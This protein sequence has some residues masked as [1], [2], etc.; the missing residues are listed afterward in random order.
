MLPPPAATAAFSSA[1]K[2]GVVFRVSRIL[3]PE[4]SI[5]L[6]KRAL[7]ETW[8]HGLEAALELEADLQ[9]E[10]GRTE[11]H[12]EGMAAFLEKRQPRFT[13]E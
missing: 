13:G 4:P 11:D 8:D 10:A 9:D 1:R 5:A 2:P 6:T 3:A 12:A 7:R